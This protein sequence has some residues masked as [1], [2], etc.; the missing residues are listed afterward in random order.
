M[1]RQNPHESASSGER[2]G[3]SRQE[4]ETLC[5]LHAIGSSGCPVADLAPRLGFPTTL[6]GVVSESV[7]LLIFEGRVER[8]DERFAL[9][10]TG[11]DWLLTTLARFLG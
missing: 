7:N 2:S 10:D 1:M 11:R 3:P 4:I 6:G 5:I 9:T 8:R